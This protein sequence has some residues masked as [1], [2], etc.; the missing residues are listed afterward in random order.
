MRK[1]RGRPGRKEILQFL[2]VGVLE[3]HP[4]KCQFQWEWY[5]LPH[6]GCPSISALGRLRMR[7]PQVS[8]LSFLEFSCWIRALAHYDKISNV[9]S[10]L[11][12]LKETDLRHG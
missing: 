6:S 1:L 5:C 3:G 7:A 4:R 10:N 2:K 8:S 11:C 9:S 12:I